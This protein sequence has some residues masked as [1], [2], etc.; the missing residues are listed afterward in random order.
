GNVLSAG[1]GKNIASQIAISAVIPQTDSAYAVNKVCCSGLKSVLL[2]T[3]YILLV[4][5]DVFVAGGI[6]IMFQA[7]YLSKPSGFGI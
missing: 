5:N 6:D 3:K 4:D 7:P 1:Q 2:S